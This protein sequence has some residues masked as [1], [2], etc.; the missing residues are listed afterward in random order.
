MAKIL[1]AH[2]LGED[3]EIE[4]MK[5]ALENDQSDA[6]GISRGM[7]ASALESVGSSTGMRLVNPL[8][9]VLVSA[10]PAPS[11][12]NLAEV[13]VVLGRAKSA[14]ESM[15]RGLKFADVALM[16][17]V[18]DSLK[19]HEQRRLAE[20]ARSRYRTILNIAEAHRGSFASGIAQT[21]WPVLSDYLDALTVLR[22]VRAKFGA[23]RSIEDS[24]L[25]N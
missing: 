1:I 18:D 24:S 8:A 22:E 21:V 6:L 11:M 4:S 7:V 5:A 13:D 3:V 10:T 2:Q 23:E 12:R 14:I 20:N 17:S 25:L 19:A 15:F 16:V 9:R